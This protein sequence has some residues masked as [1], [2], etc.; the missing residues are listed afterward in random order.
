MI[1]LDHADEWLTLG[2]RV[3]PLDGKNPGALLGCDWPQK[4]TADP[5]VLADWRRRWPRANLG[6]L[7]GHAFLALDVDDQDALRERENELGPLPPTPRYLTGGTPDRC[8]LLFAHPQAAVRT[9]PAKGIEL[10]DGSLQIMVPPSVHPVT[11]VV[12]EWKTAL[13]ELPLASLP[14]RWLK[15]AREPNAINA[16]RPAGEYAVLARGVREGERNASCARLAGY[17]LRRQVDQAVVG[18]LLLG[19]GARCQPPC[20]PDEIHAV[21]LSVARAEARR[22]RV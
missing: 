18:E 15:W 6:V 22:R 20:D 10:R 4:A 7:P 5:I 16:A 9:R 13:D 2:A 14:E 21:V 12:L 17:L 11:G 19:W 8:R 3:V 1:P